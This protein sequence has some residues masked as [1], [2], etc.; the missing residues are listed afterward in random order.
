M[1]IA[2][3]SF[4]PAQASCGIVLCHIHPKKCYYNGRNR[5]DA[6]NLCEI[7]CSNRFVHI[8]WPD[9]GHMK[10]SNIKLRYHISHRFTNC[11]I[12]DESWKSE[13]CMYITS[14]YCKTNDCLN[15]TN[16]FRLSTFRLILFWLF[17]NSNPCNMTQFDATSQDRVLQSQLT[18]IFTS[19]L[20]AL[21]LNPVQ[22][23]NHKISVFFMNIACK[24][25][26][27]LDF[28]HWAYSMK[29]AHSL[30]FVVFYHS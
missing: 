22:F 2:S 24:I 19:Q 8:L 21:R 20:E 26:H 10:P 16:I 25:K 6:I 11:V 23:R 15:Y 3:R 13:N 5:R 18:C 17:L 28:R 7:H 1:C 27:R 14:S 12:H 4:V 30:R 29:Y 9:S